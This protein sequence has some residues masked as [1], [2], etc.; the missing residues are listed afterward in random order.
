[1]TLVVRRLKTQ[2][3]N[4]FLDSLSGVGGAGRI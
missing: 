4:E 3:P 2:V 1:M